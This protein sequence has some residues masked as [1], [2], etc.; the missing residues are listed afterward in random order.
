M[1][2][3]LGVVN[4]EKVFDD[5]PYTPV[6]VND[7]SP[8]TIEGREAL[9][10]LL[11]TTYD[12]DTIESVPKCACT[13]NPTRGVANKGK[14]CPHCNSPVEDIFGS[15]INPVVW[16]RP[17]ESISYLCNPDIW[18]ILQEHFSKSMIYL[19]HQCS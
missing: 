12:G 11:T 18:S 19:T 10:R 14:I 15:D 17:P 9:S 4:H 16:I 1:G 5:L 7:F 8:E 6:F 13:D 2:Y 3:H